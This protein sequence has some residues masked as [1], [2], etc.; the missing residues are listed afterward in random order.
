MT[1]KKFN[2]YCFLRLIVLITIVIITVLYF[3]ETH[4]VER[5]IESKSRSVNIKVVSIADKNCN[6]YR[7]RY[8]I[9]A[10]V[11]CEKAKKE[12]LRNTREIK[13]DIL[14]SGKPRRRF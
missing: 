6:D 11:K 2:L 10:V 5:R 14:N 13:S 4:A 12:A 8:E 3:N 7:N 9:N 1:K